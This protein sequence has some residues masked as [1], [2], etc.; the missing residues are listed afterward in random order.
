MPAVLANPAALT[1]VVSNLLGNAV[2]FVDPGV[3][4]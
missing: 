3:K 2:K 1:Q 4:P